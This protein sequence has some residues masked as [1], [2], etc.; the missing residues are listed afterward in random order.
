MELVIWNTRS[1]LHLAGLKYLDTEHDTLH[2]DTL[3][4]MNLFN[5]FIE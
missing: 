1:R 4:E 2:H 5:T 3:S